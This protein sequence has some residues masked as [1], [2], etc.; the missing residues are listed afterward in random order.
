[1]T[2]KVVS[3]NTG[4]GTSPPLRCP[5][6]VSLPLVPVVYKLLRSYSIPSLALS[7]SS[8]T[9][10]SFGD[11][12]S[13]YIVSRHFEHSLRLESDLD[14]IELHVFTEDIVCETG[15]PTSTSDS[16]RYHNVYALCS[17]MR[18]I[19]YYTACVK[20]QESTV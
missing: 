15:R 14:A 1:M 20:I 12:T 4:C 13:F 17:D 3:I 10:T 8:P 19:P 16:D 2:D 9:F 5:N 11:A 18:R 7:S 6:N